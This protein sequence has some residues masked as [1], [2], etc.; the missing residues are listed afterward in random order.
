VVENGAIWLFSQ[1]CRAI[2]GASPGV[3]RLMGRLVPAIEGVGHSHEVFATRRL[4]RFNESEYS[5]PVERAGAVLR[6]IKALVRRRKTRVHFPIE[7]RFVKGDDI[8]LS[9]AF[10]RDSAYVA[11]HMFAG[12]P[13]EEYFRATEDIFAQHEGRP[14]WGKLHWLGP[15]ELR[16]RY[17]HWDDFLRVRKELDPDGVFLNDYLERLFGLGS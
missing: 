4:V 6:E 1:I 13:Y 5:V 14:H 15:S 16:A 9:P 7:C 10:A 17:S 11:V 8:W 12:M 2:P 3:S